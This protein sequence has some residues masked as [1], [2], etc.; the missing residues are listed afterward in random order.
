MLLS[1]RNSA[2]S[3]L[4]LLLP[5]LSA[6][7]F[8]QQAP[9]TVDYPEIL[10]AADSLP[11][12]ADYLSDKL[13]SI[14]L[15]AETTLPPIRTLADSTRSWIDRR[16]AQVDT[17]LPSTEHLLPKLPDHQIPGIPSLPGTTVQNLTLPPLPDKLPEPMNAKQILSKSK[18]LDAV[19]D[20][21]PV[22]KQRKQLRDSLASYS[23]KL[24][25]LDKMKSYRNQLP[26]DSLRDLSTV[27]DT[28]VTTA[29][30]QS[31]AWATQQVAEQLEGKLPEPLMAEHSQ[32]DAMRSRLTEEARTFFSADEE[33]LNQAK[34]QL[35]KLKKTYRQV[36]EQD[37]VFI[38]N[39]SLE[40]VPTRDRFTYGLNANVD[41][42][43]FTSW[44]LRPQ[45][46]YQMNK[47]WTVGLGGQVQAG[48]ATEP[49]QVN[50]FWKGGYGFVQREV[51]RQ[52][53]LYTEAAQERKSVLDEHPE[54]MA[55]AWRGWVGLGKQ[56]AISDKLALQLLFLWD[57]LADQSTPVRE[58]FQFRVGIIRLET[59]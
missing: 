48:I 42:T 4:L 30:Q 58:Q 38:K 14:S 6:Q 59:R 29:A 51:A 12:T 19:K 8:A 16:T 13:D 44:Q 15:K 27:R 36:K 35:T 54:R 47:V 23:T 56:V 49:I 41:Q 52:F 24:D 20:V 53:L 5:V 10:T 31:E 26:V 7:T 43:G 11:L 2:L 9:K 1:S 39:T 55:T 34:A 45:L 22:V 50:A 37:S 25:E 32:E 40:G 21:Q 18:D 33:K 3:A 17:L 57:G 46:G 28:L